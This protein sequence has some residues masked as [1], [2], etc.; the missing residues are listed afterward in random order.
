VTDL[1]ALVT[2][3]V[4]GALSY[5]DLLHVD[6]EPVRDDHGNYKPELIVTGRESGE[7]LLIRVEV[8]V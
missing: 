3:F 5:Q 6:V 8:L 4:A 1:Q 2:G 7:R